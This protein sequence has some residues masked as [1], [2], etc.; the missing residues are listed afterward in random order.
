[1]TD[2]PRR[3]P[4]V[5]IALSTD[6]RQALKWLLRASDCGEIIAGSSLRIREIDALKGLEQ[7]LNRA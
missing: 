3:P 1:M 2:T 6:E 5:E 4:A 7:W